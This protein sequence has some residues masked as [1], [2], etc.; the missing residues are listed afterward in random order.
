MRLSE[1]LT[2]HGFRDVH[3]PRSLGSCFCMDKVSL[4]NFLDG[5]KSVKRDGKWECKHGGVGNIHFMKFKHL[6][7]YITT[8]KCTF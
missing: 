7:H 1:F 4:D 2:A 5:G 6:W 3:R 8:M